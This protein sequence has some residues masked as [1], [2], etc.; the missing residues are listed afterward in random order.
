VTSSGI[1][2]FDKNYFCNQGLLF[3]HINFRTY[4]SVSVKCDI[5]TLMGTALYL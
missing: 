2:L 5:G 3:F 4:F 1:P